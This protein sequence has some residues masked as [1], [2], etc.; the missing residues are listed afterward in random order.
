MSSVSKYFLLF[1]FDAIYWELLL[2]NFMLFCSKKHKSKVE[3]C[4][5]RTVLQSP[6]FIFVNDLLFDYM[7]CIISDKCFNLR[8]KRSSANVQWNAFWNFNRWEFGVKQSRRPVVDH[9]RWSM[10]KESEFYFQ[11]FRFCRPGKRG[12]VSYNVRW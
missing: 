12:Q 8:Y 2:F 4:F 9:R 5:T 11:N 10:R 1:I 6:T 7:W 3:Y